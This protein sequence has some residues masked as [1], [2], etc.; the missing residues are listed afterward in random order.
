MRRFRKSLWL[1]AL[2]LPTA[3]MAEIYKWVDA[4][5]KTH[6]SERKDD[7]GKAKPLGLNAPVPGSA[8]AEKPLTAYWQEQETRIRQ[9][10][11]QKSAE[12]MA[13][14]P[15]TPARPRSVT[16][17]RADDTDASRCALARDVLNGSLGHP[18][19]EPIDKYD[20]E[21]AESDVRGYCKK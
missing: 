3:G 19:G 11:A 18:N 21:T 14:A 6:Y 10:Q 1:F 12:A 5:G 13:P 8:Q 4:N 7:A 20:L 2:F 9:R 16:G 15:V 17:G